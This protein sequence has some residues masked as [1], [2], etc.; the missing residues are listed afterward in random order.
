MLGLKV[1][2]HAGAVLTVNSG[3][4]L[5]FFGQTVNIAA[6]VQ[7]LAESGEICLTDGVR[8]A[9]GCEEVLLQCGYSLNAEVS[10]LKGVEQERKI[11]RCKVAPK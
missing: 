3:G 4:N 8:N 7:G 10:R 2:I 6:R 1:G 11:Y 9:P 5:D